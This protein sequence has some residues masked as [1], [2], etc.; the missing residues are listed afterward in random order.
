[1]APCRSFYIKTYNKIT[2]CFKSQKD[3]LRIDHN[4]RIYLSVLPGTWQSSKI[5]ECN[6]SLHCSTYRAGFLFRSISEWS[7]GDDW[8]Q[9]EESKR[10]C[11]G[12]V[13]L[14]W[15]RDQHKE[16]WSRTRD[17][18]PMDHQVPFH[19]FFV[20]NQQNDSRYP[21]KSPWR[22]IGLWDGEA[23]TFS[24]QSD[25]RWRWG[26]Q[27]YAPAALYPQEDFWYSFP[28]EAI[29]GLGALGQ[30][31]KFQWPHRELNSRPSGL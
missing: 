28:L 23:P 20:R 8:Q 31:K 29:L 3:W 30:L 1:M 14:T 2:K 4:S 16:L 11:G 17:Y 10:W 13:F 5:K 7:Q 19:P 21:C 22:P 26:C 24:R 6:L 15:G 12:V 9:N 18:P 25:H 27:P